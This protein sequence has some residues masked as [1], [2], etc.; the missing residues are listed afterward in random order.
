MA[1]RDQL[2]EAARYA[3]P[4]GQATREWLAAHGFR[5]AETICM[6]LDGELS[7]YAQIWGFDLSAEEGITPI[8]VIRPV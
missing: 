6:V 8:E 4:I 3:M 1:D 2:L 7:F 5:K